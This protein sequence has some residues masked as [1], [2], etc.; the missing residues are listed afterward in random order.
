IRQ[1]ESSTGGEQLST[2]TF[3]KRRSFASRLEVRSKT[4]SRPWPRSWASRGTLAG[5]QGVMP[6]D[7]DA[8]IRSA[9]GRLAKLVP[10]SAWRDAGEPYTALRAECLVLASDSVFVRDLKQ[11]LA[12]RSI[13][14]RSIVSFFTH[15]SM[16]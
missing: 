9:L 13:L 2:A 14:R 7:K 16:A 4:C 15:I 1:S 6:H 12:D 11:Y 10:S 8:I 5:R 3:S